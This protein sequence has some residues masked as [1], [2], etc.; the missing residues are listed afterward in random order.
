VAVAGSKKKKRKTG[1]GWSWRLAGL[2]LCAFFALGVITGLS[3]SGRL[4]AHRVEALLQ[5]LP[6]SS[7]SELIPT[8]YRTFLDKEPTL[9]NLPRMSAGLTPSRRAEVIALLERL[10]G[11][12][13]LNNQG[14]LS[15]PVSSA[16]TID[17]PVLSGS[18][19]ENAQPSQLLEYAGE[20]IRAE[21]VLSTIISEMQV[22]STGESRLYLDR[23]HLVI[24]LSP[25]QFLVQLARAARVLPL[26]QAHGDLIVTIDLTIPG[27]AIVQRQTMENMARSTRTIRVGPDDPVREPLVRQHYGESS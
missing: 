18:G 3:E 15:G 4:L 25:R 6:H 13:Q 7:R 10:E 14:R 20:L 24:I 17:L 11:L 1:S 22:T 8:A 27:E 19:V 12:Y 23:S 5:R 21:A 26:W 9:Q 2:A 16:D